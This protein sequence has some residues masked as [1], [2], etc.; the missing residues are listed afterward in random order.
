MNER[1]WDELKE[2]WQSAPSQ[3][4]PVARELER[5]R[6]RRKW[7]AAEIGGSSIIGLAGLGA[8]IALIVAGGTF[9][10]IAGIATCVFVAAVGT[11]SLWAL[12]ALPPRPEDAVAHAVAVA[13]RN[14]RAGVRQAAA[15]IWGVV[16]G[17]VFAAFMM[18]ARGLLT[19]EA[20]LAGFVAVGSVLLMLAGWLALAFRYYQ[21]RSAAL[22]R[23]DAIAAALEE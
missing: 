22:A 13:Q 23:L 10:V 14:A 11:I 3:A 15:M 2:L 6:R 1:E 5:L 7:L 16:V 4:E 21:A 20:T 18:L 12:R 9:F 8:G 19:T 17:L